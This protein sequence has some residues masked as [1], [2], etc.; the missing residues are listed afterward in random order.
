[1]LFYKLIINFRMKK[2]SYVLIILYFCSVEMV[3]A[4]AIWR[5]ASY[6]SGFII[7]NKLLY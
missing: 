3:P 1:M 6:F 5:L 4:L 7:E 2:Y